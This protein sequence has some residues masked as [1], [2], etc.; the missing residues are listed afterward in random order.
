MYYWPFQGG[1][2]V[3]VY[4][5]SLCSLAFCLCLFVILFRIAWWPSAGKEL[6]VLLASVLVFCCCF[7]FCFV[8]LFFF[9]LLFIYLFYAV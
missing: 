5:N 9:F 4:S 1:A 7:F 8:F 6:A 3:V 2:S